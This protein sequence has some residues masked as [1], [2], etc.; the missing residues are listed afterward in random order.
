MVLVVAIFFYLQKSR[1][2]LFMV[3]SI[4]NMNTPLGTA[5]DSAPAL[6]KKNEIY[7]QYKKSAILK[8]EWKFVWMCV[9]FYSLQKKKNSQSETKKTHGRIHEMVQ[10]AIHWLVHFQSSIKAQM[11]KSSHGW[12]FFRWSLSILYYYNGVFMMSLLHRKML[13][14]YKRILLCFRASIFGICFLMLLTLECNTSENDTPLNTSI[15][16]SSL[17]Q[18]MRM[19]PFSIQPPQLKINS[20]THTPHFAVS[21]S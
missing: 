4:R 2:I 1:I 17:L 6:Q 10:C 20:Y 21:D 11:I 3:A 9:I 19:L 5:P 15:L 14:R 12:F 16:L 7:F 8:T 18:Q 13:H